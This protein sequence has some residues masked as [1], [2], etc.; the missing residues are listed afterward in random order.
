M[1]PG[2][3]SAMPNIAELLASLLGRVSE[4]ERPLLVAAAERLAAERYRGWAAQVTSPALCAQLLACA[5]REEQIATQVESVHPHAA[6]RQRALLDANP[7]LGE[8]NRSVFA[9]R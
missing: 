8:I 5:T 3:E 4:A 7:D 6:E 9:G 2:A 1:S